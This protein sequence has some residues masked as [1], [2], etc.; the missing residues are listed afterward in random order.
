[1]N[2]MEYRL[3]TD[4]RIKDRGTT[5]DLECP[6]CKNKVRFQVFTNM[7]TRLTAKLPLIDVKTIYFL[8]CPKCASIFTVDE[9]KGDNFRAGEKLAIGNFDLKNL[10]EFKNEAE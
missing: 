9:S 6:K 4:K 10:K 1:M 8:V 3:G 5:C 7:D 2:Y